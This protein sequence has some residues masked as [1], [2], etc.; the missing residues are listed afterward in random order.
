MSVQQAYWNE[1]LRHPDAKAAYQAERR[2]AEKKKAWLEAQR[3]IE[4]R[5][6]QRLVVA[7]ALEDAPADLKKLIAPMFHIRMV[8]NFLWMILDE[9]QNSKTNFHDRLRDEQTMIHLRSLRENFQEGGE[10]RMVEL[11]NQWSSLCNRAAD[12]EAAKTEVKP[13]LIDMNTLKSVLEFGQ[14]C[15]REGNLK[16]QEGLFEEA[17]HIYSQGDEVMRKWKVDSRMKNEH[18]WLQD[19]HLAC[20]KN[21][22]QAALKLELFSTALEAAEAC[23]CAQK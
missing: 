19:Y 11:E 4:E 1:F 10:A 7:D 22:S 23:L 6:H 14:E 15:K 21:K 9:C 12:D 16:F 18:K 13:Q 8:E 5:A 3:E 17:L 20:L 2:L